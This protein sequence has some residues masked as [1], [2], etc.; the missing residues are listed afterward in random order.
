MDFSDVQWMRFTGESREGR[1]VVL[2]AFGH[3]PG[4]S[5]A[6][7]PTVPRIDVDDVS[8][9]EGDSDERIEEVTLDVSGTL[10]GGERFYVESQ[11]GRDNTVATVIRLRPAQSTVTVPF[12]VSGDTRDDYPMRSSITVKALQGSSP[13]TTLASSRLS[14]TTHHRKF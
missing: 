2:D 6:A 12:P 11:N 7:R 1:I 14:T 8:V 10:E 9:R 13:V 3:S 5:D 4:V